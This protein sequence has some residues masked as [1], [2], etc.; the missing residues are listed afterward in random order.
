M[1]AFDTVWSLIKMPAK[2]WECP[3]CEMPTMVEDTRGQHLECMNCGAIAMQ[4]A[5]RARNMGYQ[6]LDEML[7]EHKANAVQR[8][9]EMAE[10]QRQLGINV[11]DKPKTL[12]EYEPAHQLRPLQMALNELGFESVQELLQDYVRLKGATQNQEVR[13]W[14]M[15]EE[16]DKM[17]QV[18]IDGMMNR[19]N[20]FDSPFMRTKRGEKWEE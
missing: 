7:D 15:H 17:D 11:V 8:Q 5:R 10:T 1:T 18:W 4:P 19:N 14:G 16:A 2:G 9:K 13:D 3:A 6:G 20:Q 12:T